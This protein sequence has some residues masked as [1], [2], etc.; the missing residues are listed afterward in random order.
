MDQSAWLDETSDVTMALLLTATLKLWVIVEAGQRFASDREIGSMELLLCTPLTVGDYVRGQLLSLRRQFFKPAMVVLAAL[1]AL[2]SVAV[3]RPGNSG[4]FPWAAAAVL[5]AADLGAAALDAMWTGLT[6]KTHTRATL[7]TVLRILVFPWVAYS[8]TVGCYRLL[9]TLDY[10]DTNTM[11]TR[12]LVA[13]WL[14]YGLAADAYFG[15]R[16]WKKLHSQ[17]REAALGAYGV[18]AARIR[19]PSILRRR[20]MRTKLA[21]GAVAAAMLGACLVFGHS[22]AHFPPPVAVTLT[23][24]NAPLKAF[25]GSNGGMFF[26]LPDGSLWRW[27]KPDGPKFPRASAPEPIGTNKDWQKVVLLPGPRVFGLRGNGSIWEWGVF[28]NGRGTNFPTQRNYEDDWK[29]IGF[30]LQYRVAMKRDGTLWAWGPPL[31]PNT[32]FNGRGFRSAQ[33]VGNETNWAR[34][35]TLE[36]LLLCVQS[37]GLV[38]AWGLYQGRFYNA[39]TDVASN[40]GAFNDDVLG[41]RTADYPQVTLRNDGT[42]W[43]QGPDPSYEP[44]ISFTERVELAENKFKGTPTAKPRPT[45]CVEPRP[46]MKL[47]R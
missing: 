21:W 31:A 24:S 3:T 40:V 20:P 7:A 17:F 13:A 1:A 41:V 22:E 28:P 29:D 45:I 44:R 46:L 4:W 11:D 32:N 33:R 9:Q 8:A 19:Q 38:S 42:V 15:N 34:L 14:V 16:A 47:Q 37:N 6:R 25:R 10:V 39:P 35:M 2:M 5:F 27:G 36:N 12:F 23:Q 30:T 26:I 18:R 43:T